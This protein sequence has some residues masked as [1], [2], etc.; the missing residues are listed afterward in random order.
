MIISG[1]AGT[2]FTCL[3]FWIFGIF[4]VFFV[5]ANIAMACLAYA[6]IGKLMR[7]PIIKPECTTFDMSV[8]SDARG[9]GATVLLFSNREY[10]RLFGKLNRDRI[11]MG[12]QTEKWK[13][14]AH[15]KTMLGAEERKNGRFRIFVL[16]MTCFSLLICPILAFIF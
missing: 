12:V 14:P 11:S 10:A 2:L 7:V 5:P 8:I 9:D 4:F 15:E 6:I 13:N 3:I 1:L 16:F